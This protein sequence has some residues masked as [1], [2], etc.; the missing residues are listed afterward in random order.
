M[1]DGLARSRVSHRGRE[2]RKQRAILRVI[3]LHQ[4]LVRL[5]AHRGRHVAVLGLAD[6]RVDDESVGE[7]QRQFGQVL[8]GSVDRVARLKSG[9]APPASRGD[10]RSQTARAESSGSERQICWKRKDPNRPGRQA[11]G[12]RQEVADPGMR[13]IGRAIDL[14]GLGQRI[15]REDFG[16]L[17]RA[18]QPAGRVVERRLGSGADLVRGLFRHGERDRDRPRR[19]VGETHALDHARV[20]RRSQES[21][22][23]AD[24]ARR[25]QL[26]VRDLAR[27]QLD[28]GKPAGAPLDRRDFRLRDEP[29]DENAAVRFNQF[30]HRCSSPPGWDSMKLPGSRSARG[31]RTPSSRVRASAPLAGLHRRGPDSCRERSRCSD[32]PAREGR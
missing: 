19:S 12:A 16:D 24:G 29:I 1:E 17:D 28:P 15:A 32:S 23:R 25:D 9:H 13:R 22:Q 8:V 11:I 30:G 26:Q 14:E 20:V 2:G 21:R 4:D 18:P 27:V 5:E 7:L 10:F 31:F 6:Q 3:L